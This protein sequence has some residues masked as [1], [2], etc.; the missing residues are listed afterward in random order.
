[1]WI[2]SWS[3]DICCIMY[4]SR[5][6]KMTHYD[7]TQ[8]NDGYGFLWLQMVHNKQ[9][10]NNICIWRDLINRQLSSLVVIAYL[11]AATSNMLLSLSYI[12]LKFYFPF[13]RKYYIL[14]CTLYQIEIIIEFKNMILL[15]AYKNF[16]LVRL[17]ATQEFSS[18][19]VIGHLF[20]SR[21]M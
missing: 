15:L 19:I 18:N 14:R 17:K 7:Y 21:S 2:P 4:A 3:S 11:N 1:M 8:Q 5:W 20:Q 10:W 9:Y 6:R 13:N 16:F 12:E